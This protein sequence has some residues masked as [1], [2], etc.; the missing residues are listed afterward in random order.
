MRAKT[1]TAMREAARVAGRQHGVIAMW[2]LLRAGFSRA[3][4]NRWVQKGLLHREYRGVYR[5]GHRAPSIE[6]RYMAAVLACG[7]G[8]VLCGLAAGH[9][10]GALKKPPPTPEVACPTK[11]NVP[12]V[13]TRRLQ[14]QRRDKTRWRGIPTTTV[15]RTL[16]DL[17]SI[18][19]LDDLARACHEAEVRHH[20]RATTVLAAAEGAPGVAKLRAVMAGDAPALLSEI[21]RRFLAALRHHGL[22]KPRVNRRAGAHYIDCRWPAH[23]LTVELDSYRFH[24]SRHAWEADRARD[25]AAR[26]RGDSYR[27][28]TW[29]DV[30]EDPLAMLGDLAALL[31]FPAIFR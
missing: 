29:R 9:L 21:E 4:V 8:A 11:R 17:A 19:A 3:A 10:L 2:Q 30:A 14:L 22:P 26:A 23:H 24:H 7:E 15:P 27:R 12:G 20:V 28:Y 31:G 16:V 1:T 25:R 18:L 13:K 6:A 5:F